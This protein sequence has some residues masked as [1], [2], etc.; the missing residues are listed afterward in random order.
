M[1]KKGNRRLRALANEATSQRAPRFIPGEEEGPILSQLGFVLSSMLVFIVVLAGAVWFGARQVESSLES[2]AVQVLR[3]SGYPDV[4]VSADGRE[5]LAAG[6]VPVGTDDADIKEILETRVGAARSV[7]VDVRPVEFDVAGVQVPADPLEIAWADGAVRVVGT[8]SSGEVRN[9]VL[10]RLEVGFGDAVD[11]D[12]LVVVEGVASEDDWL[13][14]T[15]EAALVVAG[16]VDTG[17]IIV[18]SEADVVTVSA[19]MPDRQVRAEARRAVEEL[20][21]PSP[22]DFV[23]ALTLEDAPPPPPRQEV[24]ELQQ[25][26]DSL[27]A[28]KVVEFELASDEL[29]DVGRALLDE[30]LEALR[31]VPNVAV[32][33]AGHADASGSPELNLDLSTRRAEAVLAYLVSKGED[34]SRF[35]VI[36]YGETQ[37]I[38]DN[39]T[40]EGRARNRRI[41]FVALED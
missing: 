3:A 16:E 9:F 20:L 22:L 36:G 37:P 38:A 2:R 5:L 41:E 7:Q 11:A 35:Q 30:V 33:I 26:L 25:D 31:T 10:S 19:I 27:I 29:T 17:S 23:S 1:A 14:R 28:G 32:E 39:S 15:L 13:G 24:V 4:Q 40:E 34:R 8:V 6:Q 18:N 21:D 12:Q